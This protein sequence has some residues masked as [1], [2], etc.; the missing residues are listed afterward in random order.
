M[1]LSGRNT[2]VAT[3]MNFN[4]YLD[5]ET[6]LQLNQLTKRAGESQNAL[7]RQGV[8][9]WFNQHDKPQWR[10]EV[11]AFKGKGTRRRVSVSCGD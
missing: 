11:L 7:V 3:T 2:T 8:S 6:G 4:I 9:D 10:D 5:C 1:P